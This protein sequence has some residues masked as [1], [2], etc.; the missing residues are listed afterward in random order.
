MKEITIQKWY[1]SG[2]YQVEEGA[3]F[4]IYQNDTLVLTVQTE[5][6]GMTTFSL[7]FGDYRI[8][9]VTGKVGYQKIQDFSFSVSELSEDFYSLYNKEIIHNVPN[10]GITKPF[11]WI[12]FF[13]F[14]MIRRLCY[15]L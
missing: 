7:P 5:D 4:E 13:S 2:T 14:S 1:G 9:Q 15:V 8:H 10:T 6:S 3:T 11:L 12:K